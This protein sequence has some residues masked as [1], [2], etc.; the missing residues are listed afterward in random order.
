MSFAIG[1][2]GLI[3]LPGPVQNVPRSLKAIAQKDDAAAILVVGSS[4]YIGAMEEDLMAAAGILKRLVTADRGLHSCEL[5][6]QNGFAAAFGAIFRS[7]LSRPWRRPS[8]APCSRRQENH[9]RS[10]RMGTQGR[11]L[12]GTLRRS[13]NAKPTAE[14]NLIAK[15]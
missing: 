2:Y 13:F 11:R 12:E 7:A 5:G 3:R 15:R 6:M 4:D 1:G 9:F 8:V 14:R 10:L